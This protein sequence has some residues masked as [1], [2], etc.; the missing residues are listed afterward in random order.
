MERVPV[1]VSP[2][3]WVL[4]GVVLALVAALAITCMVLWSELPPR[5]TIDCMNNLNLVAQEVLV[6]AGLI[7][8]RDLRRIPAL[9]YAF[10]CPACQQAY[11]YSPFL[12]ERRSN[13]ELGAGKLDR[14]IAW[15]PIACHAGKRHVLRESGV[16]SALTEAQFSAELRRMA[17]DEC[18]AS[19]PANS[20]VDRSSRVHAPGRE[21]ATTSS[22]SAP[23]LESQPSKEG[24][25]P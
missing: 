23:A 18:P 9:K 24:W 19:V 5:S 6:D 12:G 17:A 16:I 8:D 7:Q 21:L 2:Y 22:R 4:L 11:V 10:K 14:M 25:P 15:C 3:T 20:R 1:R 13:Q